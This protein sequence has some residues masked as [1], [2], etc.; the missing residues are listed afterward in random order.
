MDGSGGGEVKQGAGGA[1]GGPVVKTPPSS[2]GVWGQSLGVQWLR[3]HGGVGSIPGG[4]E[5]NTPPSSA[6][7][8]GQSLGVQRLRRHIPMRGCGLD[9]WL[10]S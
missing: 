7:V 3:R 4:P 9:P 10:G 8:W 2:A 5:A 1:P 6:G